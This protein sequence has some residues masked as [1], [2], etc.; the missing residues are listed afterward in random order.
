[1]TVIT[2]KDA[3]MRVKNLGS[4]NRVQCFQLR[5]VK[6]S[7]PDEDQLQEFFNEFRTDSRYEATVQVNYLGTEAIVN[8]V[9]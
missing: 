7:W 1:M 3:T 4:Q 5:L 2:V 9:Q 8:V 6:G